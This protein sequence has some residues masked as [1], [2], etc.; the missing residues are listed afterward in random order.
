MSQHRPKSHQKA[1]RKAAAEKIDNVLTGIRVPDLPYPAARLAPEAVSDWKPLLYSCWTEQR[2]ERVTH[3][4]RSVHLDWSVRQV[5]A[6]YIADRIMDVYLKTSGLHTTL[7]RRIARLRFYLAW[8]MDVDGHRAFSETLLG[9]LDSFQEWRGWSDSGGRSAKALLDQLDAVVVAVSA[10]FASGTTEAVDTFCT[11][12]Q[13]EAARRNAQTGKL[14]QRLLETEQGAAR[15]R[16]ADQTARALV[17]R[18]LQGRKLPQPVIRFIFDYWQGL[19]KQAVWD[20]GVNGET[21]RHGNKLLEWLVWIGD[22]S[23]SDENRNRLYHVGEQLGDRIMD[24]W[25]RVFDQPLSGSA[26]AGIE[27]VMVSRLR[28]EAP[29]LVDALPGTETFP[30]SPE[31]LGFEPPAPDQF[32]PYEGRWFV[33]G[34]GQDEQRRYFFTL[35]EESAEILWTNGAG[36]KLGL[37]P[38]RAF[39]M[40][41]ESGIMRPLPAQTPFGEVF[42]ETVEVLS[43]AWEKQR[44]ERQKAAEAAKARAEWLRKEKEAAERRRQEQEAARRA[45]IELQRQEAENQRLADEKAEQERLYNEKMRLAQQQVERINLGGWIAVEAES[46]ESEPARLKLAVRTN[47]SRKLIFVDR[48]GL[49]RREFPEDELVLGLVE[50][51]IRIL[52]GATEFDETLSRVVGRIRIGRN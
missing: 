12:W 14:R 1:S 2:D 38:W 27:T 21:C 49:N 26:L 9:W 25:N 42:E 11:Q 10:S 39:S 17:G 40:A 46:P 8:R 41:Q 13:Q 16:R 33:E 47:A 3:V 22:P 29:E 19:L 24:V 4:L 18:A 23:L 6:A 52:G 45:A 35:L 15:Q 20:S 5:N 31:W 36:V 34:A 51:R 32:K 43:A 37:Q 44:L 50:G 28:G 30:W 48:L 7:A